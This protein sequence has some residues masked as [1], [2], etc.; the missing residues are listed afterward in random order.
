MGEAVSWMR[1]FLRIRGA[2]VAGELPPLAGKP[3]I[4]R[5]AQRFPES[6]CSY[7]LEQP[8]TILLISLSPRQGPAWD[9]ALCDPG[10]AM[11]PWG[12]GAWDSDGGVVIKRGVEELVGI[13]V[14]SRQKRSNE[15]LSSPWKFEISLET[16]NQIG[17]IQ[18]WKTCWGPRCSASGHV[19]ISP[20]D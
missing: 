19:P 17:Q 3:S 12:L 2:V 9:F 8:E 4:P 11:G 14:S 20:P 16:G 1:G 6:F 15:S 5:T 7:S 18:M 10:M 13:V